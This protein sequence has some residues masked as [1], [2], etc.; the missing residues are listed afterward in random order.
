MNLEEVDRELEALGPAPEGLPIERIADLDAVD[1]LLASLANGSAAAKPAPAPK[2]PAKPVA[3]APKLPTPKPPAPASVKPAA[4]KLPTPK[5]P[6][7]AAAAP[8]SAEVTRQVVASE[9]PP[10]SISSS[11]SLSADDLFADLADDDAA[12]ASQAP[13]EATSE[14]SS[15]EEAAATT[16]TPLAD[17]FSDLDEEVADVGN[18]FEE[19]APSEDRLSLDF[20][21]LDDGGDSEVENTSLFSAADVAAIRR[22]SS[23]PPKPA[24]PATAAPPA[25]PSVV[26]PKKPT[27]PPPP[28]PSVASPIEEL[29]LDDDFELLIDDEEESVEST[30]VGDADELELAELRASNPSEEPSD[31]DEPDPDGKKG[32]FK[33]LFG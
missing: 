19:E 14:T 25:P 31:D 29:V 6:A 11:G 12:S 23:A 21:E 26:P 7:P 30:F 17:L 22:A 15:P 10:A 4:P 32:F 3:A 24:A 1:G 2:V 33:K 9:P 18:L 13:S 28:P 8:P 5:P 16:G 27:A 20:G